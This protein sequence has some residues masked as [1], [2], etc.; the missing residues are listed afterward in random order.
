MTERTDTAEPAGVDLAEAL[1]REH[2][3]IDAGVEAY[4][5]GLDAG[6]DVAPLRGAL[7]ALRRH[8]Y[9][10]ERFL[11]P[12][13]R[14]A[15]MLMPILVMLQEHGQLWRAMD[16]LDEA[17]ASGADAGVLREQC[18]RMLALLDSHNTKEEPIVYPRADADLAEHQRV[19]LAEVLAA[20]TFPD[21][22]VCEKATA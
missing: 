7:Q 6:G 22:W 15:G 14:E 9:L 8:I 20:G 21:G 2:H 10:E 4:L 16:D 19:Q 1:T 18:R 11:F 12:P 5:A 3:E 17:L 13:L